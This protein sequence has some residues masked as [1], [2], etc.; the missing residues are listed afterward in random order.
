MET[1]IPGRPVPGGT[2][3]NSLA[4]GKD[5]RCLTEFLREQRLRK[6][7]VMQA[8]MPLSTDEPSPGT[9]GKLA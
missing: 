4:E 6:G 8:W 2:P 5:L 1:E 3:L 7:E 9:Q